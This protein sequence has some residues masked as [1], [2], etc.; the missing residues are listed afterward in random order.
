MDI[1]RDLGEVIKL[2]DVVQQ[3]DIFLCENVQKGLESRAYDVGRLC[4]K[5]ENGVHQFHRMVH[6]YLNR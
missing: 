1:E 5:H 4:A 6:Q 2:S 3:E